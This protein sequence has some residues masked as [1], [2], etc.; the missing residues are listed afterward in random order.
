MANSVVYWII[1]NGLDFQL[2]RSCM[3]K[4]LEAARL[5]IRG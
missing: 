3:F 2:D 4:A 1:C 5:Q